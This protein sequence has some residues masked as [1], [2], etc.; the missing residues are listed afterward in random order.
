MRRC[1]SAVVMN[2]TRSAEAAPKRRDETYHNVRGEQICASQD[3]HD[4]ANWKQQGAYQP[5]KTGSVPL[6]PRCCICALGNCA[7]EVSVN[8]RSLRGCGKD[9]PKTEQ[10]ASHHRIDEEFVQAHCG[11][12]RADSRH[13]LGRLRCCEGVHPG[14]AFA[15]FLQLDGRALEHTEG[16]LDGRAD[17]Q[18]AAGSTR[19]EVDAR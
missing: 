2:W 7:A 8:S 3:N 1:R 12:L 15:E 11:L 9:L 10:R 14:V 19:I 17:R 6:I 18:P 13:E 5:D 16:V 4:E